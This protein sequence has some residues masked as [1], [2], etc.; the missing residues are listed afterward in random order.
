LLTCLFVIAGKR[1]ASR[2]K[3]HQAQLNHWPDLNPSTI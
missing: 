1:L 3:S 2:E